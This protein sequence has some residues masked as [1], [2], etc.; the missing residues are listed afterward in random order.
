MSRLP[1][2]LSRF[3]VADATRRLREQSVLHAPG[4]A[5]HVRLKT[6]RQRHNALRSFLSVPV[7]GREA[8]GGSF[9]TLHIATLY[10][11]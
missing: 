7:R 1:P 3:P 2:V 4:G 10:G 6:V 11:A 9:A 8:T 5:Q